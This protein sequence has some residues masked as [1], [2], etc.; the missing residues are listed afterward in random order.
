MNG[1]Q[2]WSWMLVYHQG[3]KMVQ[4]AKGYPM[5]R[6]VALTEAEHCCRARGE[7]SGTSIVVLEELRVCLVLPGRVLEQARWN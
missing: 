3:R 4:L 5:S 6:E 2:L 7:N 1:W